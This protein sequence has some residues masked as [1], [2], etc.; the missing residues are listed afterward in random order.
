LPALNRAHSRVRARS[1]AWGTGP[2]V[3]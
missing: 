3:K 1:A 2:M